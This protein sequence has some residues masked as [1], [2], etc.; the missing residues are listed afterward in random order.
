LAQQ[1]LRRLVNTLRTEGYTHLG[2]DFESFNPTADRFWPK[3]FEAY[4]CVVA[5]RVDENVLAQR[6][7]PSGK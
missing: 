4:T 7:S 5:R 2:V 6:R 1:L 3:H